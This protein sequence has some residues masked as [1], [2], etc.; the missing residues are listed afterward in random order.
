MQFDIIIFQAAIA[1]SLLI[2]FTPMKLKYF[3]FL[4]P[5]LMLMIVTSGWAIEVIRFHEVKTIAL[6]L[7]IFGIT[8]AFWS[9][10]PKLVIDQIS[11][12]FILMI[13][14]ITFGS[15]IYAY[16]YL[17]PYRE[18]KSNLGMAMHYFSYFLLLL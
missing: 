4:I 14:L 17:K 11:A 18:M 2:F 12:L 10:V 3:A 16:G 9:N 13:N 15:A 6:S 1:I 8:P 5:A 7:K